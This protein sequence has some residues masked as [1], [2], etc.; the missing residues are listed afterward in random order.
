MINEFCCGKP[1]TDKCSGCK[2][3]VIDVT[4]DM[5]CCGS[6]PL[7]TMNRY[8]IRGRGG[9]FCARD[10]KQVTK[11]QAIAF[12]HSI[13]VTERKEKYGGLSYFLLLLK[14]KGYIKNEKD[15]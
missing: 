9:G 11:Q 12:W 15:N 8:Y 4:E 2:A 13:P 10:E 1:K 6:I 5:A 3:N 14:E 7:H